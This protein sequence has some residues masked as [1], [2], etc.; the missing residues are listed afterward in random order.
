ME[1]FSVTVT[2]HTREKDVVE[3]FHLAMQPEY[4]KFKGF[5]GRQIFRA[6]P[7]AMLEVVR[8]FVTT[9]Q[10]AGHPE[11]GSDGSAIVAIQ[12]HPET[13]T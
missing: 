13:S 6:C 1:N 8:K 10:I 4:K 7:G 9:E 3:K 5:K 12:I 11:G 2:A